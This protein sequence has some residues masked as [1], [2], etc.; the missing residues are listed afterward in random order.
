MSTYENYNKTSHFFDETRS[1]IGA[2]IIK[3]TLKKEKVSLQKQILLD[4][5]CGTGLYSEA[6]V[7]DVKLIEAIDL[8]KEMLVKA[9]I[10]LK[11]KR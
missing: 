1:A 8:N 6:L 9:N 5:G 2:D 10:R 4:A 7:N 11:K 3:N